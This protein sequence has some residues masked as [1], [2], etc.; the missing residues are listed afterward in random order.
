MN[1]SRALV[2]ESF[3]TTEEREKL[4]STLSVIKNVLTLTIPTPNLTWEDSDS[5]III[6]GDKQELDVTA[7]TLRLVLNLMPDDEVNSPL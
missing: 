6:T 4:T 1:L 7:L 2:V 3:G 5:Y